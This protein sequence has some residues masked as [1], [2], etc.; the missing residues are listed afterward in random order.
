MSGM[1]H[2]KGKWHMLHGDMYEGNY[3]NDKKSGKGTY[4]WK[5]GS[6]YIGEF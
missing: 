6:K 5:N 4:L 2:G 3:M 1:R